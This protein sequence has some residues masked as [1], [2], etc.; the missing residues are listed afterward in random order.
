M[1]PKHSLSYGYQSRAFAE[2]VKQILYFEAAVRADWILRLI[3]LVEVLPE[4][5]VM[6]I[7]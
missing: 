3:K 6:A 1:V 2:P 7:F 4:R 5:R